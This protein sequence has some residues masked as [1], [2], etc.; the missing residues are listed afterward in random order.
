MADDHSTLSPL[1]RRGVLA[2]LSV[3]TALAG[4]TGANALAIIATRPAVAAVPVAALATP[5]ARP[6]EDPRLIAL[7]EEFDRLA[8]AWEAADR[9]FQEARAEAERLAPELPSD[10][11]VVEP[12]PPHLRRG[13]RY[14]RDIEGRE[15]PWPEKVGPDG[16][17]VVYRPPLVFVAD[18]L[19][20]ECLPACR[21]R[22]KAAKDI[23]QRLAIA[24]TY[25]SG[26]KAAADASGLADATQ[27]RRWAADDLEALVWQIGRAVPATINGLL[28]QA[29]ALVTFDQIERYGRNETPIIRAGL[30]DGLSPADAIYTKA[31]LA[32]GRN[33]AVAV[34]R[35]A[36][37]G[38][39]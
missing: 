31:G 3:A 8:A 21:A 6:A 35:I 37:Q 38:R 4:G 30:R 9:R 29:R 22:S 36:G 1:S 7:G 15:L 39:A 2:R 34:L 11:R 25:E 24:E 13:W 28:I 23:R 12:I 33:L 20:G 10:L 17:S 18:R 26:V 32:I 5:P 16:T 27:E 19:A 14:A